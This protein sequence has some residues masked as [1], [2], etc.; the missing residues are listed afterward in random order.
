[1]L[2]AYC[3]VVHAKTCTTSVPTGILHINENGVRK[4]GVTPPPPP[5]A[6]A[7]RSL[8]MSRLRAKRASR[9]AY[10]RTLLAR[11]DAHGGG[12]D[13]QHNW[14]YQI[15]SSIACKRPRVNGRFIKSEEKV[16]PKNH[17]RG[18]AG[19]V[20]SHCRFRDRGAQCVS[21]FGIKWMRGGAISG[22]ATEP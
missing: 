19:G 17:A 22:N 10:G 16:K 6:K 1:M 8:A 13:V 14:R 2:L 12:F 11:S 7:S 3:S 4:T 21:E 9:A 18:A 5:C 20:R 15:R